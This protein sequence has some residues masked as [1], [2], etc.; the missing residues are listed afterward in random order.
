MNGR[1]ARLRIGAVPYLNARPLVEGL[2]ED[3]Q[4]DYRED[5]PSRLARDLADGGLD[6]AL[7][8]AIEAAKHPEFS[9]VSGA[10]LASD[11]DVDSVLLKGTKPIAEARSIA[12]DG[13]SLCAAALARVVVRGLHER[14]DVAFTPVGP[15]PD[16]R[17][18]GS[19]LTLVIGDAALLGPRD[20]PVVVDLGAEWTRATGL[21]FVWAVWLARP[22]A[23]RARLG[24]LLDAAAARG[25]LER[26]AHADRFAAENRIERDRARR[27][28]SSSIRFALDARAREGLTRFFELAARFAPECTRPGI[29]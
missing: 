23:D 5:L 2:A 13:A 24:A 15:A 11:G 25:L 4:V 17:A 9:I 27:Y 18:T 26:D 10:C 20:L 14:A 6:V 29:A 8:S 7:V 12:L 22:S 19:D 1:D 21:P 3:P 28:L 16:P